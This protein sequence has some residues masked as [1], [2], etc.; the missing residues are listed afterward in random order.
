MKQ[1]EN[2][3]SRLTELKQN[4]EKYGQNL[5]ERKA[6]L[7]EGENSDQHLTA[8]QINSEEQLHEGKGE[9]PEV[10]N[11]VYLKDLLQAKE[12]EIIALQKTL[13][14]E[15]TFREME[16]RRYKKD[17]EELTKLLKRK[18]YTLTSLQSDKEYLYSVVLIRDEEVA[19]LRNTLV[20][21]KH[22]KKEADLKTQYVMATLENFKEKVKIEKNLRKVE[23]ERFQAEIDVLQ[24]KLIELMDLTDKLQKGI[25]SLLA[26][27]RWKMGNSFGEFTRKLLFRSKTPMPSDFLIKIL[28]K[29]NSWKKKEIK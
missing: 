22:L 11:D 25:Q 24:K 15:M 28:K 23:S 6:K 3:F 1:S 4:Q 17:H 7:T 13:E 27:K 29:Y 8:P 9:H 16:A 21:E 12:S 5:E 19:K 2:T 26:S 14:R 10:Q 18:D 20:K